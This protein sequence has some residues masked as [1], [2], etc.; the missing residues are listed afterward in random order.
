MPIKLDGRLQKV[1]ERDWLELSHVTLQLVYWTQ[2][3]VAWVLAIVKIIVI[4]A[5][6]QGEEEEG[7]GSGERG[8]G[9]ED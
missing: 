2:N 1:R 3:K 6:G 5:G 8:G 7:K 9:E 4:C